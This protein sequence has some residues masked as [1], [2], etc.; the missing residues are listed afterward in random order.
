MGNLNT[1]NLKS[2]IN[3]SSNNQLQVEHKSFF[4]L[5]LT[6]KR[7]L[8]EYAYQKLMCVRNLSEKKQIKYAKRIYFKGTLEQAYSILLN[9]EDLCD[10]AQKELAVKIY[11]KGTVKHVYDLIMTA[12]HVFTDAAQAEL[13]ILIFFN[14]T[15]TQVSE[16][17]KSD[18]ITSIKAREML[19]EKHAKQ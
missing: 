5:L 3:C 15:P 11:L 18:K 9:R 17:I 13:M 6:T 2:G 10:I 8:V 16:L 7:P 4:K 14:G 12:D 1:T 19:S